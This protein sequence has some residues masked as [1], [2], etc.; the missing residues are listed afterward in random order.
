[1]L[2]CSSCRQLLKYHC[3][4]NIDA[5]AYISEFNREHTK[6]NTSQVN[7]NL[8]EYMYILVCT[9]IYLSLGARLVVE[10]RFV[11]ADIHQDIRGTGC[12]VD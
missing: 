10:L 11:C 2:P 8:A 7:V 6:C 12:Q 9:A 5:Y 1:M 3:R 4:S